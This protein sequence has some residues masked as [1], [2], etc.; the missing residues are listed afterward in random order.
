MR[1]KP[2]PQQPA[3]GRRN[4][5]PADR[6]QLVAICASVRLA[7]PRWLR[8]RRAWPA[9]GSAPRGRRQARCRRRCPR[10]GRRNA[11]RS[12]RAA[13]TCGGRVSSPSKYTA[14][15]GCNTPSGGRR[16]WRV[17]SWS[18]GY[19]W[20]RCVPL[21]A[22]CPVKTVGRNCGVPHY[23]PRYRLRLT[24]FCFG[25][26][27]G[28][29]E[30]MAGEGRCRQRRRFALTRRMSGVRASQHPPADPGVVVQLVR[31]PACH[32]GG[33]GFESRPL[34]QH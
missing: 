11:Q 34:R 20:S 15:S 30:G 2:C 29:L 10:Y 4:R 5:L 24:V 18:S 17:R 13:P 1:W 33:R 23:P 7:R 6:Y 8:S 26:N 9:Q 27:K 21:D 32:A 31:I 22:P 3:H 19:N 12:A 16:A 28:L 25:V 14:R